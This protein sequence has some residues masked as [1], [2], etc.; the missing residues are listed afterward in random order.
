[1]IYRRRYYNWKICHEDYIVHETTNKT[2]ER[3]LEEL[4]DIE[5]KA[6]AYDTLGQLQLHQQNLNAIN[7]ELARRAQARQEAPPTLP[8]VMERAA[9]VPQEV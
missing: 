1:M 5:L 3:K 9:D 2:M 6:L 7:T 8:P 4:S